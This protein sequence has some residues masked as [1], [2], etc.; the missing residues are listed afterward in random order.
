[1]LWTFYLFMMNLAKILSI[2]L[3]LSNNHFLVSSISV[4]F[5]VLVSFIPALIFMILF[6]LL[7][8]GFVCCFFSSCFRCK[9]RLYMSFFFLFPEIILYF[10]KLPF[11]HCFFCVQIRI[12]LLHFHCHLSLSIFVFSSEVH[13]LFIAH[14]SWLNFCVLTVKEQMEK[15][16]KPSHFPLHQKA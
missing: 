12:S 8:L 1:M 5:F 7:I 2:L 16:E 3:I 10:C 13:W 9:I 15:L 6:L 11:K 14:R 4:V